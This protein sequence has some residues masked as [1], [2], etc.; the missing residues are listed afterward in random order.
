MTRQL[1]QGK[2][3]HIV[4]IYSEAGCCLAMDTGCLTQRHSVNL[5]HVRL[6]SE[7]ALTSPEPNKKALSRIADQDQR[8]FLRTDHYDH[9]SQLSH[10]PTKTHHP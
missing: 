9:S 3:G 6:A 5:P 10:T 1:K 7:K 8:T 4:V 2:P